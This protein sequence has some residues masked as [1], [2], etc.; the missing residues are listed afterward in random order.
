[1]NLSDVDSKSDSL[2]A[3]TD[4]VLQFVKRVNEWETRM[5]YR[6]RLDRGRFVSESNQKLVEGISAGELNKEYHGIIERYC[7]KRERKYGGH[8]YSYS[9]GGKF[10]DITRETIVEQTE[11]KPG[12]IEMVAKGGLF[13]DQY[14]KFV[15]FK[16]K[17]G[18]F[19]DNIL[20][21]IGDNGEWYRAYF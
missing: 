20:S 16:K 1:V 2:V 3:P 19:L 10:R 18:W 13:A 11:I 14:Y 17:E 4:L 8:P 21:R 15:L 7:T 6:S 5:Y 9:K 12:R